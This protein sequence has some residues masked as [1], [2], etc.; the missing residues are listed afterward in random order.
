MKFLVLQK[1]NR[2]K[3]N[4]KKVPSLEVVETFLIRCNLEDNS[5]QQCLIYY[6]LVLLINLMLTG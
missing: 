3:K 2:Q 4:K 6:T 1:V 5:Y